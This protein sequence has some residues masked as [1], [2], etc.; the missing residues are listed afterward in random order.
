MGIIFSENLERSTYISNIKSTADKKLNLNRKALY[1]IYTSF[2]RPYLEY[3][4]DVWGA[5]SLSN[6][7]KIEQLQLLPAGLFQVCPYLPVR[8]LS[9]ISFPLHNIM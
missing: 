7:E 9:M 8:L 3:A 1:L 4:S 6:T 2:I 5:F